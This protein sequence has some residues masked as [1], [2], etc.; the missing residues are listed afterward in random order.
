MGHRGRREVGQEGGLG[1]DS[2]CGG[3]LASLPAGLSG[4]AG[5]R[6]HAVGTGLVG[7]L[8]FVQDPKYGVVLQGDKSIVSVWRAPKTRKHRGAWAALSLQPV[9]EGRPLRTQQTQLTRVGVRDAEPSCPGARCLRPR[10]NL[11]R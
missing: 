9:G 7:R 6:V 3:V 2:R 5:G 8:Y 4:T 1:A 11:G 10:A